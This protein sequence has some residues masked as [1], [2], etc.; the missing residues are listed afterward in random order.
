M[1]LA[2]R[3]A[4]WWNMPDAKFEVYQERVSILREHCAA[5]GRNPQSLRLTWFGRLA[6]ANSQAEA[7]ALRGLFNKRVT[8]CHFFCK[9][10]Q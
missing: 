2:A 1:M 4:D 5:I 7:E 3:Y 6:V 10:G 8:Y 9:N